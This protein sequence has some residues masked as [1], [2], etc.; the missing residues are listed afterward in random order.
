[1]PDTELPNEDHFARQCSGTAGND[2]SDV[3][4]G[5]H[6]PPWLLSR[7]FQPTK[8]NPS[9]SGSWVERVDGDFEAQL[10]RVRQELANSTR[11]VNPTYKLAIIQVQKTVDLGSQSRR[12]LHVVHTPDMVAGLPSHSEIRGI[13]PEDRIL[14]QKLA[15]ASAIVPASQTPSD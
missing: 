1:M 8:T 7:A 15:D 4:D 9:V 6:E 2:F 5:Y 10:D 13:Q 11:T 3:E 12:N 14:Q